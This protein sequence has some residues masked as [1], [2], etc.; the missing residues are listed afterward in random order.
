MK[1]WITAFAIFQ[2]IASSQKSFAYETEDEAYGYQ[3]SQI[4]R[5]V[6]VNPNESD[7]SRVQKFEAALET[8]GV[9]LEQAPDFSHFVHA[10]EVNEKEVQK[11]LTYVD[12]DQGLSRYI[13]LLNGNLQFFRDFFKS[14]ISLD[15]LEYQQTLSTENTSNDSSELMDRLKSIASQADSEFPLQG[16]KVLI[17]PGHMGGDDWDKETG[18]FVEVGGKKVSEGNLTLWTALLTAQKLEK[19]GAT[20]LLTRDKIGTVSQ[21]NP[22]T[23]NVTPYINNYFYNSMDDWMAPYLEKSI[24]EVKSTI[25]NVSEV[26]KAYTE[27]QKMQFFILG[28]D[29]E[30]RSVMVDNFNP[31]V[32]LDIHFD[33][34]K[35]DALQNKEQSL[36]AFVPGAFRKNETGSRIVRASAL[37]HLLEVRRWN[38][39][40]DLADEVTHSLS[41]GLNI[42][43]MS[44]PEAFTGIRVRDGVYTRNLYI[45]RRA[46]S[47]LVVYLECLHYDYV[48]EFKRL[49]IRN[50][51]GSYHSTTFKYPSRLDTISDGIENGFVEYFKNLKL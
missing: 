20:V 23:F 15:Y 39:S 7:A 37:K 34:D 40:V 51:T 26:K 30:A 32:T 48:K 43:R 27:T 21:E 41:T 5:P 17:D 29:L 31:D 12:P 13:S 16:L 4:E 1:L 18:K 35:L 45:S 25:K 11:N 50:R 49:T 8:L 3:D 10:N 38:Q 24:D 44:T 36:E 14:M 2:L 9:P 19:L 6:K 33:A 46:L 42:P 47:S 22:K 28:A